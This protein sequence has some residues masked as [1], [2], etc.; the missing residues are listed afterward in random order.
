MALLLV[1]TDVTFLQLMVRTSTEYT[2]DFVLV[3]FCVS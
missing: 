3:L 2:Q 1:C